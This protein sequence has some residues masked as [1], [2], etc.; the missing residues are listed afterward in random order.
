MDQ[1]RFDAL[2]RMLSHRHP[3]RRTTG[4]VS[5]VVVGLG[6]GLDPNPIITPETAA[7]GKHGKKSKRGKKGKNKGPSKV[8]CG[9]TMVPACIGGQQLNETT[10]ECYCPVAG[11]EFNSHCQECVPYRFMGYGCCTY[12]RECENSCVPKDQCCPGFTPCALGF[13]GCCNALA[14]EEC[15]Q[16]DGCCNTLIGDDVCDGKWCCRAGQKCCPGRGCIPEAQPC[17]GPNETLCGGTRCCAAGKICTTG[18]HNGVPRSECC[19]PGLV[20]C[21]GICCVAGAQCCAPDYQN[22][23]LC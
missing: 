11:A 12:E 6:L 9:G 18:T 23:C 4:L 17:C 2:A 22:P 10:C 1:N 15:A 3:R 16:F 14:G 21:D 20:A 19:S 5:L 13:E 8:P 7:K